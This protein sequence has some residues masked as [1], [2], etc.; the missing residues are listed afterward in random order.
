MSPEEMEE[1]AKGMESLDDA[2]LEEMLKALAEAEGMEG[3]VSIVAAARKKLGGL[4]TAGEAEADMEGALARLEARAAASA[5]M[6]IG[7]KPG[8]QDGHAQG[9]A[10]SKAPDQGNPLAPD[11]IQGRL[12][13]KGRIEKGKPFM[14]LPK[15]NTAGA[16][17]NDALRQAAASAEES[18]GRDAISPELR[19]VVK[20]YFEALQGEKK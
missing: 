14:G 7:S 19:P 4:G 1:L 15:S 20:R 3:V 2:A 10:V 8:P 17:L 13:P 18:L 6:G 5:G 16:E 12:D 9:G 11:R